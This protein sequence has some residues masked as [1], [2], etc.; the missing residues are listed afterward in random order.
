MALVLLVYAPVLPGD[1]TFFYRDIYAFW[2]A[3]AAGFRRV[4]GAGGLP[5]WT[6]Y[7]S[8]GLPLLAD[9]G[10]QVLYPFTWLNLWLHQVEWY[11]AFALFHAF[12]AAVGARALA[13]SLGMGRLA[14]FAAGGLFMASGPFQSALSHTVH[15]TGAA[16]M[17]WLVW[18]ALRALARGGRS[19][20]LVLGVFAALQ[21][22]TGSGDLLLIAALCAA[23]FV[24]LWAIRARA[25]AST[26]R[27]GALSLA[28]GL[29]LGALLS[30][31][32]WLPTVALLPQTMRADPL[33]GSQTYWS[34][35]PASVAEL[36]V[37]R[38]LSDLPVDEPA[39]REL[40]EGREPFWAC[41]YLGAAALVLTAAGLDGSG[42]ARASGL[43]LTLAVVASLGRFTPL[44]PFLAAVTPLA[45]VRYPIKYTLAVGL[46]WAL[47]AARGV[48]ASRREGG[49]RRASVGVLLLVAA[50]AMAGGLILARPETIDSWLRPGA[51]LRMAARHA[52]LAKLG[53]VA[54][55]AAVALFLAWVAR[56]RPVA[57]LLLPLFAVAETLPVAQRVNDVAPRVLLEASSR[58]AAVV[59]EGARLYVSVAQP[60]EWFPKQLARMPPGWKGDWAL[61]LGR[62]DMLAPPLG[63]RYGLF[64]SYDGDVAGFAPPLLG[65]LTLILTRAESTPLAVRLLQLGGVSFVI[66]LD[67]KPWP[68]LAPVAALDSVFRA[69]IRVLA[70]PSPQPRS[71]LVGAARVLPVAEA[72]RT[73]GS[74]DFDPS[75]EVVLD[76]GAPLDP[77]SESFQGRLRE[78]ERRPDRAS[79]ETDTANPAVL[80]VLD[81]Y[82]SGWRGRVDGRDAP[83]VRANALFRAV[84]VPAGRHEVVM[85]YRP[86]SV[87]WGAALSSCGLLAL[88]ALAVAARARPMPSALSSGHPQG[89]ALA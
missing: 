50:L 7:P 27:K 82:D 6:P 76:R 56:N 12:V 36:L 52:L 33:P 34:L 72:I 13:R 49:A 1:R 65:N 38:V 29:V 86:A 57:W 80:V 24:A 19:G 14:A 75:R 3:L 22:L 66:T 23:P 18:A 44:Y 51:E 71:Y 26:F 15:F 25:S 46:F 16:W 5:L 53:L 17:P 87:L 55:S 85:E 88:V 48:D 45:F 60:L 89:E 8:F 11:K 9:P 31:A 37:P 78:R 21:V 54:A 62:Q 30:A 63:T 10:N 4:V 58:A 84:V 42:E 70:V 35:H 61:A 83:I 67:D 20:S 68:G 64:G 77:P 28:G 74:A 43:G 81:A 2:T 59:P 39:R 69:P 40:Y 32:Q 73:L 47:L 41:L 79:F